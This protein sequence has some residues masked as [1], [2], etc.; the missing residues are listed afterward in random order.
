MSGWEEMAAVGQMRS[1]LDVVEHGMCV[2][3]SVNTFTHFQSVFLLSVRIG[4]EVAG[5]DAEC[6]GLQEAI[7]LNQ[8]Q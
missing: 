4:A 7:T 5:P 2:R 3:A 1:Y 6:A 8:L